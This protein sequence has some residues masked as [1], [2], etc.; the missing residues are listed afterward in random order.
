MPRIR[1]FSPDDILRPGDSGG[2]DLGGFTYGFLAQGDSWFSTGAM[3]PFQT[4]NILM[5]LDLQSTAYAVN[6]ATP[7]DTLTHMID[8]RR[9]PKFRALLI[10]V[11]ASRWDAILLS[12]GGNDL[13]DAARVMPNTRDGRPV[14]AGQRIFL[15]PEEWTGE[16]DVSR[17]ISK[18]GWA[19][20][21]AYLVAQFQEIVALRDHR[22]SQSAGAPLFVHCY[23]YPMPRNSPAMAGGE[24]WLFPSLSAYRIPTEDW[25]ALSEYLIGQLKRILQSLNLPNLFVVDTTGTLQ[26]AMFGSQGLSNDWQNEIHPSSH[27]YKQLAAK[28]AAALDQHFPQNRGALNMT[29]A[30]VEAIPQAFA[31]PEVRPPA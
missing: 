3:P 5:S 31:Q 17:Y 6:C 11:Q 26:P 24:A 1:L 22:K 2:S 25:F 20:F 23:D 27:G 18:P 14:D 15:K 8:A 10:G 29:P 19:L 13:I 9:D 16:K 28:Y 21:E 7:D 12:A 4:T 30:S